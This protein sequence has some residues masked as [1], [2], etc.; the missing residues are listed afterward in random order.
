MNLR[1]A[2]PPRPNIQWRRLSF[3]GVIFLSISSTIFPVN[4]VF[5]YNY[6][7]KNS[8]CFCLSHSF[9]FKQEFPR[10]FTIITKFR[11]RVQSQQCLFAH[12][13]AGYRRNLGF[14]ISKRLKFWY[15]DTNLK[16][17]SHETPFFKSLSGDLAFNNGEFVNTGI[18][19]I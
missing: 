6:L 7:C 8:T 9:C 10:D 17:L 5:V 3:I 16:P 12:H 13:L 18:F 1:D 11:T 2:R 14:E 4:N 19:V 15:Q